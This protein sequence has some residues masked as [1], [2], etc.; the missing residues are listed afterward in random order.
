MN[1][2]KPSAD[3]LARLEDLIEQSARKR[4]EILCMVLMAQANHI[5]DLQNEIEHMDML[6][7]QPP[8]RSW[9]E[10]GLAGLAGFWLA[11]GFSRDEEY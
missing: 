5:Q 6:L 9:T 11:G 8:R 7:D 1:T 2:L 4:E 3:L 10:L